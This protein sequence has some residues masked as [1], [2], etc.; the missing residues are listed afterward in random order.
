MT[1]LAH[2]VIALI[3]EFLILYVTARMVTLMTLFLYVKNA[4]TNVT[5]V[6]NLQI[7]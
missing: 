1:V 3:L 4:I 6:C 5:L 2:L 7:A